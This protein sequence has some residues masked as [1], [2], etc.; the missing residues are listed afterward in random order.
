MSLSEYG[1]EYVKCN[2][3]E[4]RRPNE[5]MP[6][7]PK[8]LERVLSWTGGRRFLDYGIGYNTTYVEPV[9]AMG[10]DL[11]GCDISEAVPYEDHVVRL[12]D[13][14]AILFEEPFDGI[15]SQDCVEHFHDPF[16]DWRRLQELIRPGG[17]ILAG[18]P[19]LEWLWYGQAPI[20]DHI[21]LQTPWHCSLLSSCALERIAHRVGLEM[22]G[23]AKIATVTATAFVLRRPAGNAWNP[24]DC[25]DPEVVALRR[26]LDEY[27]HALVEQQT[28]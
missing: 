27:H 10:I 23:P 15:I 17:I 6:A 13:H 2:K 5:R 14:E 11:W 16:V 25:D 24:E 18:T 8:M 20:P 12:P 4:Q 1:E 22:I 7:S 26:R 28:R 19:A 3:P 9:R 21:Y